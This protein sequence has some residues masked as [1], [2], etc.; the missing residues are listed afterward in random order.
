M[1]R[2]A[3]WFVALCSLQALAGTLAQGPQL[4]EPI[5]FDTVMDWATATNHSRT[6]ELA[7]VRGLSWACRLS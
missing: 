7:S 2:Y 1:A 5:V 6:V 3:F 4:P